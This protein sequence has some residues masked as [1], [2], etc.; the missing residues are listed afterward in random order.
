M[1]RELKNLLKGSG[2]KSHKYGAIRT[3]CN[4]GHSH[5]SKAEAVHC[6][7]LQAQM[8][9]NTIRGLQYEKAFP[10]VMNGKLI[11]THKPDFY[12]LKDINGVEVAHVDEVK[13][14][15]TADF[16]LKAKMFQSLY[17][18]VIYRIVK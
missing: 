6:W 15:L 17:P 14:V 11:G 12:Y 10:L 7:C 1:K 9:G 18:L 8:N 5:P 16:K 13:G 2:Y 3:K 4:L